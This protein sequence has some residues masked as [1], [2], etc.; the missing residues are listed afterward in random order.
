M[1]IHILHLE[2][3]IHHY[4]E[5][6]RSG[7]LHFYRDEVYPHDI[8]VSVELNKFEKNIT[9]SVELHTKGHYICDRCLR[10]Y[11]EDYAEQ[12]QILFH[13]G[14][15]DLDTDEDDVVLLS[16]EQVEV[17]LNPYIEEHL[18]LTVPMKMLCKEDCKGICPGC[19]ADLNVES[20]TCQV[21]HIDP[22]WEKLRV[23]LN[24]NKS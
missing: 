18:I 4:R 10:E 1:K 16:P 15:K 14:Q 8:E 23:L 12:F 13:L 19:G 9:C 17:D 6:I 5:V 20:C 24:Q 21:E 7:S 3:G 22:R 2:E 11:E